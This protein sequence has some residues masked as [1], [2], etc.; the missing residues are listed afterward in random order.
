MYASSYSF[1]FHEL[2]SLHPLHFIEMIFPLVLD[3]DISL[4]G[5]A[6]CVRKLKFNK[7]GGIV[8]GWLKS[9][10]SMVGWA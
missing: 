1:L 4:E 2:A 6:V 8:V 10:F 5:I 3:R 7:T 9:F